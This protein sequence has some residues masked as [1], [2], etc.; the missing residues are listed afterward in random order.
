MDA[1]PDS[2]AALRWAV[3][4][5]T[6]RGQPLHVVA[7]AASGTPAGHTELGRASVPP[8]PAHDPDGAFVMAG[9]YAADRLAD[10]QVTT[11]I[12]TG[13]PVRALCRA[14]EDAELL[15]VSTSHRHNRQSVAHAVAAH[16]SCPVVV[17]G[18]PE[19][20]V[21]RRIVV[22]LDGSAESEH[23]LAFAFDE[24]ARREASI[25]AVHSWRPMGSEPRYHRWIERIEE[26]FREQ[27]RE[28]VAPYR[29]KYPDV[30]VDEHVLQGGPADQLARRSAAADL[31]VVG[32]RGYGR[33][34]GR[35]LG[36][37]SQG[38]LDRAQGPV[39]V[40]KNQP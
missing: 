31:V 18:T 26:S 37:V 6:L 40:V 23:A 30:S 14:A 39:A 28:S 11:E 5:A 20:A 3:G 2:D 12:A 13:S 25:E 21:R 38:L 22:G 36:S 4:A 1:T 10:D 19:A 9:Q 34:I 29:T 35:L 24:A 16:A 7:M 8:V 33:V 15:V 17:V 32:S 27:L